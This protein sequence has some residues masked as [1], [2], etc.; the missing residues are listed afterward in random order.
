[1][2]RGRARPVM[3]LRSGLP[4]AKGLKEPVFCVPFEAIRAP[5]ITLHRL[6]PLVPAYFH[7]AQHVRAGLGGASQETC[8]LAVTGEVARI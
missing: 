8:A 5:D 2:T 4:R 7:H 1:M 6:H 3:G